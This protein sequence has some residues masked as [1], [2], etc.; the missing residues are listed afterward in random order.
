MVLSKDKQFPI[1]PD[2]IVTIVDPIETVK[3]MY[4]EK[5]NENEHQV[6]ITEG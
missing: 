6:P 1:P 3:Q 2:W 4:E 5:M